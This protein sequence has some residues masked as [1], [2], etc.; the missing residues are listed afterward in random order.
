M[1]APRACHVST[2]S[3]SPMAT[4][5]Y[6]DGSGFGISP[7]CQQ[8]PGDI[9]GEP[10]L[11]HALQGCLAPQGDTTCTLVFLIHTTSTF[12]LM[13]ALL[14]GSL[15]CANDCMYTC[16]FLNIFNSI[17]IVTSM[18]LAYFAYTG[19]HQHTSVHNGLP[20]QHSLCTLPNT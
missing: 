16:S 17:H 2:L 6:R 7:W 8:H 1:A 12:I 13:K 18:A 9:D 5:A 11:P 15:A 3:L 10:V 19:I 14:Q 20:I 4:P